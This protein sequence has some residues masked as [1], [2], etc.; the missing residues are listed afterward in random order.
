MTTHDLVSPF[1][2]SYIAF[3]PLTRH[4]SVTAV[5]SLNSNWFDWPGVGNEDDCATV[6]CQD[7]C[8]MLNNQALTKIAAST[9]MGPP[10]SRVVGEKAPYPGWNPEGCTRKV[11]GR[12]PSCLVQ[13]CLLL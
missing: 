10:R 4:S 5:D 6:E 13:R 2:P 3:K 8:L 11:E 1:V 12:R 7:C 9:D